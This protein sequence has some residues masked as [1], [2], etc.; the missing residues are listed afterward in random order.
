M[1]MKRLLLLTLLG[2]LLFGGALSLP[3]V[4][5][6]QAVCEDDDPDDGDGED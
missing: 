6:A 2:V 3:I 1:K 5:S 4:P